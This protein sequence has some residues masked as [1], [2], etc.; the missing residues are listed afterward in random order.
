MRQAADDR[1]DPDQIGR[2]KRLLRCREGAISMKS[3]R[4][5]WAMQVGLLAAPIAAFLILGAHFLREGT[6]VLT[7]ACAAL[8]L[9]V[10][11]RKS[12]VPRLLQAALVLGTVEW[13]WTAFILVQQRMAEGR[14]W[15]RMAIILGGVA[16]VTAGSIA[17]VEARRRRVG[18]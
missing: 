15:G 13:A 3:T 16:L 11:W 5:A 4:V 10:A 2:M 12:W 6:W 1:T 9:A 7:A 18:G 14:P 8:A 17:A